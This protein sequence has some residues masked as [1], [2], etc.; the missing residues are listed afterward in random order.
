MA[1]MGMPGAPAE[2]PPRE[3]LEE[4]WKE[5]VDALT[6]RPRDLE[7]LLKA[8]QASEQLGRRSEAYFYYRKALL[9]DPSKSF[10]LSKLRPLAATPEQQ[11][12]L[13]KLSKLPPSFEACLG[14]IFQY[15][16]RGKGLAV[17]LLGALFLWVARGLIKSGIGTSGLT[18]A[19]ASGAY[20]AM[21][22][23]DVCH[24]TI[25]GEDHL[26]D[27]P[28][29]LRITEFFSDVAKFFV[30]KVVAFLPAILVVL[31]FGLGDWTKPV[32]QEIPDFQMEYAKR[33]GN[34]GPDGGTSTPES[35]P[36]PPARPPAPS[37]TLWIV[38]GPLL[39]AV[40]WIPL[41]MVY[42]P[43]AILSNVVMG[44]PWTCLNAPFVI[45]SIAASP[46]N[47]GICLAL[48][49]GTFLVTGGAEVA[50]ALI[51]IVPTG[52]ALGFLELYGM[53]VLMRLMGQFYR[54][55]QA[56][57]GWMAD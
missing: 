15:P 7:L 50:A 18:L 11:E 39:A 14:D 45:R 46:K 16:V 40:A 53:T 33:R 25:N 41:G 31:V 29:P 57:L 42:L 54:L 30:A 9:L 22:Y 28:D 51:G 27:W 35:E 1:G 20:M 6:E 5:A 23:I 8:G 36:P 19:G 13:A 3:Q 21:F 4:R 17:L 24:S 43:M 56:K 49:F 2:G 12:E 32:P 48:Y 37:R 26:P 55:N 44:S 52:L 34:P 10:L 38:A 47:Y